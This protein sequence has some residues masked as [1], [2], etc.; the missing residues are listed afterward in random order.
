M[1][2][3]MVRIVFGPLALVALALVC[4]A[5]YEALSRNRFASHAAA[6]GKLVSIGD[7]ALYVD[8]RGTGSP[9]VVFESGLGS[10]GALDWSLVHD[11]VAR[12]TR[13]CSYSRA[14]IH[15][16][17]PGVGERDANAVADDLHTLLER[18]GERSPIVLVAHSLGGPYAVTYTRKFGAEVAGLVLVDTLHPD[19]MKRM[20][21]AG[22][23][24]PN[25]VR[26]I[27]IAS[28][29]RWTGLPR[30]LYP[31]G[32]ETD[33]ELRSLAGMRSELEALE[34]TLFEADALHQFG[35]RPVYVLSSGK[36]ED[37]F[38]DQTGLTAEQGTRFLAIKR[39][40]NEEQ[41]SWSSHSQHEV[42]TD[43]AHQIQWSQPERVVHAARWVIDAVRAATPSQ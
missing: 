35:S 12:T 43:S 37:E 7:R 4:G 18:A 17:D 13:A 42:V 6:P 19:S 27:Q 28:A 2:R 41:A 1:K 33:Y 16:S 23:H 26:P 38:L 20:E 14:G 21:A 15:A 34:Q 9:T 39:E 11:E 10:A 40:L 30:L 5:T 32:E 24:M 36:N 3:W 31:A 25:L 22:I 8:C 29:L